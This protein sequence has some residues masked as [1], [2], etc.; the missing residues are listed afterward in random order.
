MRKRDISTSREVGVE[1]TTSAT[2]Y[3][4]VTLLHT[5]AQRKFLLFGETNYE[6]P[7]ESLEHKTY[8]VTTDQRFLGISSLSLVGGFLTGGPTARATPSVL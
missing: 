6:L 1:L 8:S 3:T 5:L 4:R 2:R 7:G